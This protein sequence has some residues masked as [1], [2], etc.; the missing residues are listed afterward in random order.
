[1]WVFDPSGL[2]CDAD[3]C[4]GYKD[5]A[6][7]YSDVDHLSEYGSVYVADELVKLIAAGNSNKQ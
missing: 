3:F 4:Y 1:M 5:N 7:L 6:L 2:F